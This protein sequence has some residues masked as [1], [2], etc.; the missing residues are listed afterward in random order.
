MALRKTKNKKETNNKF[1]PFEKENVVKPLKMF[2]SIVPLGQ[3]EGIIKIFEELGANY[4]FISNGEGTGKNFLPGLLTDNKK[5]I[6]FSF[7]KEEKSK[8][9]CEVLK[10]RF[11]I[12][13]DVFISFKPIIKYEKKYSN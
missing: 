9:I 11:A 7:I 8:E 13:K 10:R 2:I 6:I 3:A 12:S 1:V 4:S 5:Q